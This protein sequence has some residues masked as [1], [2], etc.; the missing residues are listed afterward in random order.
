MPKQLEIERKYLLKRLPSF[1]EDW[2]KQSIWQLY[3]P[4]GI[5][6][7]QN[8]IE[9]YDGKTITTFVST[10]KK[11]LKPGVYEEDENII[12][13]KEFD[14]LIQKHKTAPQIIKTRFSKKIGKVKWDVDMYGQGMRLVTAEVE[15]PKEGH[16]FRIPKVIQKEI[17]MEVTEFKEFSNRSLSEKPEITFN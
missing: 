11:K 5:R 13:R 9:I 7:R 3:L 1:G 15:L 2:K 14:S 6:L 10:R 17:I 8:I 16:K 12:S 4:N